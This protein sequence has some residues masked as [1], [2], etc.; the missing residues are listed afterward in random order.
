M[1]KGFGFVA[2][3]SVSL[4]RMKDL[5]MQSLYF[6]WSLEQVSVLYNLPSRSAIATGIGRAQE[7][8]VANRAA[9]A[10]GPRRRLSRPDSR[11]QHLLCPAVPQTHN[12]T[13]YRP[14]QE[15]PLRGKHAGG[16]D[17]QTAPPPPLD[18]PKEP[19]GRR[20]DSP[21]GLLRPRPCR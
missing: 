16:G 17:S 19:G 21:S 18:P 8:L 5:P 11:A 9:P 13:G 12:L 1:I 3:A 14:D 10:L 20:A 2:M 4:G 15:A 6:L 7:I